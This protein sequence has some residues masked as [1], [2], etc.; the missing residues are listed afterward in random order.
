MKAVLILTGA[1]GVGKSTIAK[2]WG[3]LN[4]GAYINCDYL[5]EWILKDDFP[6]WSDDSEIFTAQLASTMAKEYLDADMSVAIEN[7]WTPLGL[8]IIKT[9][10]KGSQINFKAVWLYCERAINHQ[11]DQS[12]IPENQM[13]ERVDIVNEELASYQ[14]P[15]WLTKIDTTQLTVEQTVNNINGLSGIIL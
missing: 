4:Q 11:R 7:V 2:A 6:H 15:E 12:R 3:T 13:K 10:L 14:W 1:C 8:D 9:K 5:T